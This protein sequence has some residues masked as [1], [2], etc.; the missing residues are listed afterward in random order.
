MLATPPRVSVRKLLSIVV[1]VNISGARCGFVFQLFNVCEAVDQG[2][3]ESRNEN[4]I[5]TYLYSK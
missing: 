3:C 1:S 5:F 2:R 4:S